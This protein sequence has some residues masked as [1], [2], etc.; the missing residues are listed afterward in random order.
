MAATI[1][2][3]DKENDIWIVKNSIY[4]E[5]IDSVIENIRDSSLIEELKLSV[6]FNGIALEEMKNHNS[7]I[8]ISKA[9]KKVASQV[10]S[11]QHTL[12]SFGDLDLEICRNTFCE[13]AELLGQWEKSA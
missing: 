9:M 1:S 12:N 13:L 8:E 6:D 2:I 11:G 3:S 5:Y 7:A 4:A 10:C